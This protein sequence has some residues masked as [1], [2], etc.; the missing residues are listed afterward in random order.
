MLP[1]LQRGQSNQGKN[2]G[3]DPETHDDGRLRPALLLEMVVERRHSEDALACQLEGQHLHNHRN[4][5]KHEQA[6][7][8][9]END[10]MLD[11]DGDGAERAA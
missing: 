6:A 5:L 4:G 1:Q 9:G 3:N 2:H 8:D 7:D 10:L 11:G